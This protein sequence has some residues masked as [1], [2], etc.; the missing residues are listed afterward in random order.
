MTKV[1]RIQNSFIAGQL[2]P[3]MRMRSDIAAYKNGAETITNF[4]PLL[5]GGVSRRPG[6]KYLAKL[7]KKARYA[8][9]VFSESQ[10]YIVAFMASQ[11]DV[12]GSDGIRD[13]SLTSSVPYTEAQPHSHGRHSPSSNIPPVH[14]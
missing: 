14:R 4:R 5:H 7:D 6:T 8:K 10:Q 11:V 9:F 13:Q 1:R 12:Y 3:G 2:E